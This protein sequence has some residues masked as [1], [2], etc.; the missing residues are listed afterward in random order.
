ML[1]N[2][3]VGE[4]M[5]VMGI[6]ERHGLRLARRAAQPMGEDDQAV[7]KTASSILTQFRW[8]DLERQRADRLR[9]H[10]TH[11]LR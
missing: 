3:A 8:Q 11:A 6:F 4:M 9:R 5:E 10:A 2:D 1:G 7:T